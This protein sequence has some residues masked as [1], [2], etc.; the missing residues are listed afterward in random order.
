MPQK[1]V[2]LHL[3]IKYRIN[4]TSNLFSFGDKANCNVKQQKGQSIKCILS[5]FYASYICFVTAFIAYDESQFR[6]LTF[7]TL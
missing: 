4:M 3:F 6:Q 2:I 7:Q 1:I 5:D